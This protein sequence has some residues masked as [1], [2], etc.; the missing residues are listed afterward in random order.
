MYLLN[1]L[2]F[3]HGN[4]D[5]EESYACISVPDLAPVFLTEP[6][7]PL[8]TSLDAPPTI[9][10]IQK[11]VYHLPSLQNLLLIAFLVYSCKAGTWEQSRIPPPFMLGPEVIKL[12][13][14]CQLSLNTPPPLGLFPQLLS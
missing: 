2:S 11:Q 12:C 3:N 7:C 9:K 10:H 8:D 13:P 4:D 6:N 5:S 1:N 14:F